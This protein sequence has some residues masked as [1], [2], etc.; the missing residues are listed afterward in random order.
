MGLYGSCLIRAQG[1]VGA[2]RLDQFVAGRGAGVFQLTTGFGMALVSPRS[3]WGGV[4]PR[5]VPDVG[6]SQA[7]R[8]RRLAHGLPRTHDAARAV[9]AGGGC[10][11]KPQQ[12][13]FLSTVA[14]LQRVAR[15][16]IG[17]RQ[18]IARVS[19]VPPR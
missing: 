4:G 1:R 18:H 11:R 14:P 19:A 12:G 10:E 8:H 5:P 13:R 3:H 15:R 2:D 9:D 7:R 6:G 17:K 16:T